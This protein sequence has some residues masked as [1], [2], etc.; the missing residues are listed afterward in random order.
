MTTEE[1]NELERLFNKLQ[2]DLGYEIC[3]APGTH[4]GKHIG[5]YNEHGNPFIKISAATLEI[6]VSKVKQEIE[7]QLKLPKDF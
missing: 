3:I 4:D 6:A 5:I 2:R 1:I 7:K